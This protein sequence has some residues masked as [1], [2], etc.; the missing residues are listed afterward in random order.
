MDFKYLK[1]N[2]LPEWML[3]IYQIEN[4]L[5][6]RYDSWMIIPRLAFADRGLDLLVNFPQKFGVIR[7][8]I[9]NYNVGCSLEVSLLILLLL[10]GKKFWKKIISLRSKL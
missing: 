3:M 7:L 8:T 9:R 1:E 10:S 2:L 6:Y 5:K 4:D